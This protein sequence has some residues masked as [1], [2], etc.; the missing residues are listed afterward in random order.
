MLYCLTVNKS[1]PTK[2]LAE[3]RQF[4]PAS[5]A[6]QIV[7]GFKVFGYKVRLNLVKFIFKM[8]KDFAH[9]VKSR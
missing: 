2:R 8:I 3:I 6:K 9:E 1:Q 5:L 7:F 4:H